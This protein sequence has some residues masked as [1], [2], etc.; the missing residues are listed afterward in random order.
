MLCAKGLPG[1]L[2]AG[3]L[4]GLLRHWFA[5]RDHTTTRHF[6]NGEAGM[7][8]ANIDRD[9]LGHAPI[10][11]SIALAPFSASFAP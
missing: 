2:Q 8:A 4:G 11:A 1:G 6:G 5:K 7:G 10:A 3:M 9:D